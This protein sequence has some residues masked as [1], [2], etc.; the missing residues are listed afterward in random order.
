MPYPR[1]RCTCACVR[2]CVL[3]VCVVLGFCP[4]HA[5]APCA[6]IAFTVLLRRRLRRAKVARANCHHGPETYHVPDRSNLLSHSPLVQQWPRL[7]QLPVRQ[8]GGGRITRNASQPPAR[9]SIGEQHSVVIVARGEYEGPALSLCVWAL[10]G[11]SCHTATLLLGAS[12]V[13]REA[14]ET[15]APQYFGPADAH[16]QSPA[17][18]LGSLPLETI[19]SIKRETH[20]EARLLMTLQDVDGRSLYVQITII[21]PTQFICEFS[22]RQGTTAKP[23]SVAAHPAAAAHPR[24]VQPLRHYCRRKSTL[25]PHSGQRNTIGTSS[26]C[27]CACVRVW[28]RKEAGQLA[29]PCRHYEYLARPTHTLYRPH[30]YM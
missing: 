8:Y 25:L 24:V 2:V 28:F 21:Q 5:P 19:L 11:F 12:E 9:E 27:A 14:P 22:K 6:P 3:P 17:R 4:A 10:W 23:G 29:L 18:Y 15:I 7:R 20:W 30:I 13:L 16:R 1:A 26:P